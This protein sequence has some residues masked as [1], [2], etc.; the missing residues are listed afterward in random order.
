MKRF[1]KIRSQSG[2]SLAETLLAVLILLLVAAMASTGISAVQNAY[3]KVVLGANAQAMLGTAVTA[4]RDELGTAYNIKEPASGDSKTIT[5]Y[6]SGTGARTTIGLDAE[7]YDAIA[8]TNY[9]YDGKDD[10]IHD[11]GYDLAVSHHLVPDANTGLY[12][13][14]ESIGCV[15]G[16]VSIN[17]LSVHK[18]SNDRKT[19]LALEDPLSIR[20]LSVEPTKAP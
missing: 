13:T 2:F 14:Y 7:K 17:G 1:Q 6:K 11:T 4:L 9:D 3:D 20:V 16:I 5:F 19:I 15:N 8:I 18:Q 10:L 12:V